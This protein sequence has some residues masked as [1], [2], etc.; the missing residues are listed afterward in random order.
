MH[1]RFSNTPSVWVGEVSWLKA[2]L[3]EDSSYVPDPVAKVSELI[4]HNRFTLVDD[5]LIGKVREALLLPNTTPY[6]TAVDGVV[7]FL[8]Q[9]KGEQVFTVSW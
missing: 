3:F 6:G 7:E 9:H 8:Q 5:A 4:P 1:D 2:W